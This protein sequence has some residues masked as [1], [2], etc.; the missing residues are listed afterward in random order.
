MPVIIANVGSRAV[1][2]L[3]HIWVSRALGPSQLGIASTVLTTATLAAVLG[4]LG[5][6]IIGVREYVLAGASRGALVANVFAL[7]F[8]A[9]TVLSAAFAL[10]GSSHHP[11][12]ASLWILGILVVYGTVMSPQWL[13]QAQG[14]FI[15]AAIVATVPPLLLLIGL[16]VLNNGVVTSDHWVA[17]NGLSLLAPVVAGYLWSLRELRGSLVRPSRV[18]LTALMAR[19]ATAAAIPVAVGLYAGLDIPLAGQLFNPTDVGLLRVAQSAALGY[20]T[21]FLAVP[22]L[23]V[24][25]TLVSWRA[26]GMPVFSRKSRR[27]AGGLLMAAVVAMTIGLLILPTV[28]PL[29][30]SRVYARAVPLAEFMVLAKCFV[31][32][33]HVGAWG[34]LALGRE[35]LYLGLTISAA[36]LY[37]ATAFLLRGPLGVVSIPIANGCAE[38]WLAASTYYF[39]RQAI[40]SDTAAQSATPPVSSQ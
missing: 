26:E 4:D 20:M 10:W 22:G 34:L 7:R 1:L 3:V 6:N 11:V 30:F 16:A 18:S 40:A 33:G 13:L 29:L 8:A 23:L 2:L 32:I 27:L 25:P 31:L 14:R 28:V 5:L 21:A 35:R 37:V 12:D 24:Y 38:A 39:V 9:A 17:L 19:A 36:L 15:S